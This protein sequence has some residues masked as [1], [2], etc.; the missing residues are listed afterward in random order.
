MFTKKDKTKL[1]QNIEN[2]KLS[3]RKLHELVEK[4]KEIYIVI[5]TV[6]IILSV[7]FL[8]LIVSK[9]VGSLMFLI[10]FPV[11]LFFIIDLASEKQIVNKEA[12]K[13][14]LIVF[15]LTGISSLILLS[16][17][18]SIAIGLFLF[19]YLTTSTIAAFLIFQLKN[20]DELFWSK[21][22]YKKSLRNNQK[23]NINQ[24]SITKEIYKDSYAQ[25]DREILTFFSE[26]KFFIDL[27][28]KP[29]ITTANKLGFSE[30]TIETAIR[31]GYK[32]YKDTKDGILLKSFINNFNNTIKKLEKNVHWGSSLWGLE[33]DWLCLIQYS[34]QNQISSFLDKRL[35]IMKGNDG[36]YIIKIEEEKIKI[37]FLKTFYY[38]NLLDKIEKNK[39]FLKIII[40]CYKKFWQNSNN[41]SEITSIVAK[42][43][44]NFFFEYINDDPEQ[45]TFEI[46]KEFIKKFWINFHAYEDNFYEV[47]YMKFNFDFQKMDMS[48][49]AKKVLEEKLY[50]E[51][52]VTK[53]INGFL[54]EKYKAFSNLNEMIYETL[55]VD[56]LIEK[57]EKQV[58]KEELL[59]FDF[60]KQ[61]EE[62]NF[63]SLTINDIDLMTSIQFEKFLHKYFTKQGYKCKQTKT[64]GD[65]GVD[66]IAE[67][68]G[69][70]I[71]I[72]VK[73]Y[74]TSVGNRAV[75]E[76]VAGMKYYNANRGMVI[77]NSYFTKSAI[78]LAKANNIILWDKKA[79]REKI[80]N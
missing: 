72:Q 51:Y 21:K 45:I 6:L 24:I 23:S 13:Y 37:S 58:L 12:L 1:G 3:P 48:G 75:Q 11:T 17:I 31:D 67:K 38:I 35:Q 15:A 77:T 2:N 36:Y 73:H 20:K 62:K 39:E 61:E 25:I 46:Y 47:F 44:Y 53:L 50:R 22:V 76:V 66:L 68:D 49:I 69:L 55:C 42:N 8:G 74:S 34:K 26:N 57:I 30:K 14:E 40:N 52:N 19:S 10:L 78:E 32:L 41:R 71:A 29:I 59:N 27:I 63:D 4:Q 43:T 18:D 80:K 64:S 16:S 28:V 33:D 7:I 5:I 56:D 54:F 65:Q 9:N 79:L 70:I 60:K